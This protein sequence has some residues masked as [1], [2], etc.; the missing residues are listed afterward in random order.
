MALQAGIQECKS[1]HGRKRHCAEKAFATNKNSMELIA[2]GVVR[3]RLALHGARR[4]V[5]SAG[6]HPNG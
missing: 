6:G 2:P 3:C 5:S 4:N 1:A